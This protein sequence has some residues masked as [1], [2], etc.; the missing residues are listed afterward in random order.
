MNSARLLLLLAF[1][2]LSSGCL[3]A[4]RPSPAAALEPLAPSPRLIV[5]QVFALDP[6][7]GFAFVDLAADAPESAL[8]EGAELI[9]RTAELRETG[10]LRVSRYTR[11]RTLGTTIDSGR[12]AVGDEVV[13]LAP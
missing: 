11:G 10:R 3:R 6:E 12:P 8:V 9:A 4:F 5:G 13:W 1:A 2:G 7:R